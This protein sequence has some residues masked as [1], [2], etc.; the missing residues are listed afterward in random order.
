MSRFSSNNLYFLLITIILIFIALLNVS[1]A[2]VFC[3]FIYVMIIFTANS[4]SEIYGQK[5][6]IKAIILCVIINAALLWKSKFY[7][8][9]I[10]I[11][12]ILFGSL[13]SV[14]VSTY[15]GINI[16]SRLKP[17][18]DFHLRNFISLILCSI[19]DCFIMSGFLLNKFST[20]I[21]LSKFTQDMT[22][23]FLYSIVISFGVLLAFY[24]LQQF[25]NLKKT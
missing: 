21:V 20:N 7:I 10:D 23:K 24:A 1:N 19:I 12:A 15:C 8:N 6:T 2:L 13:L 11:S 4:M 3:S 9:N 25:K 16:F 22:F 5:K 18:Y 17:K 14:L